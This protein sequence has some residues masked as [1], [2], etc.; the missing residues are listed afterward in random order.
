MNNRARTFVASVR[1]TGSFLF[2]ALAFFMMGHAEVLPATTIPDPVEGVWLGTVRAPQGTVAEIGLEFFRTKRG[3]LIFKLNFPEMFTYAT[4]FMIPVETDGHGRYA[5]TPNFDIVLKLNGDRLS[6]T[7]GQA[8]MPL[9]LK[10]GA[11]FPP[12][13]ATATYPSGPAPL[14]KY[15]LGSATWAAPVVADDMIYVGTSAG[16]FHAVHGADGTAAWTWSGPNGFDGRAAVGTNLVYAVDTKMNLIALD[17]AHGSLRW[18]TS[19]HDEKIAGKPVSENPTFNH[20]AAAPLLL[21]GMIYCGS[22]DGGLYAV[23]A[24]TGAKLWRHEAGAPVYSGVGLDGDDILTFGTMDG[25]VVLLDRHSRREI[26]RVKTGG[27]VVTTPI[28]AGNRLIAGSRDYLLYGF[29]RTD[30]TLAWRYSYWFSWIESSPVLVDGLL[31]IGASDYSRVTALD[32]ATG[33]AHWSTPVR[34]MNWGSP[35][36]TANAVVTGTVA[37]NI[38]GTAIAHQGGIMALNRVTGAVKWQFPAASPPENGFG[39]YAGSLTLA[40]D[41]IIAAGFDGYLIALPLE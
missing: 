30:G 2:L 35:L 13:P 27:S 19:L 20:R 24:G 33:R 10:R 25:S 6:G 11:Q 22:S 37:Q 15:K 26:L 29:N 17:R 34:G 12:K 8:R 38:E 21:D 9:D 18:S 36:V 4:A 31:Y 14:W 28:V 3:T 7:F 5:I 40:S 39:G 41:K 1:L 32:P 16:E 23:D